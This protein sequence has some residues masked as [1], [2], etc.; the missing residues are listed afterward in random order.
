M[1]FSSVFS[2]ARE[3]NVDNTAAEGDYLTT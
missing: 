1:T 3:V 2:K